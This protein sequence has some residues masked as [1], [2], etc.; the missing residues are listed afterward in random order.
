MDRIDKFLN[1]R[2]Q[3]NKRT[4]KIRDK[5]F[6]I[7]KEDIKVVRNYKKNVCLDETVDMYR[8][9]STNFTLDTM[10]KPLKEYRCIDKSESC[11]R[12]EKRNFI[13]KNK[14]RVTKEYKHKEINNIT[15]IWQ[16][17][18]LETLNNYE[19]NILLDIKEQYQGGVDDLK[20]EK[21]VLDKE[22]R[23]IYL[24]Q[25]LPRERKQYK[26]TDIIKES[27]KPESLKPYPTEVAKYWKIETNKDAVVSNDGTMLIIVNNNIL[28]VREINSV[29]IFK[30]IFNNKI[31]N[32]KF[33]YKKGIYFVSCGKL[34][35]LEE[36]DYLTNSLK[37]VDYSTFG[38]PEVVSTN[39]ISE[40]K[41]Y[42]EINL[43]EASFKYKVKDYD[44]KNDLVGCIVGRNL[45][46]INFRERRST[47]MY[48]IEGGTPHTIMFHPT[49][50]HALISTSNS[51]VVYDIHKKAELVNSKL[52]S[53][54]VSAKF[55][56]DVIYV[57]N[58]TGIVY[59]FDYIRNMIL[60]TMYQD[61]EILSVDV[62]Q[63]YN[64]LS[65]STKK[66][67]VVFYIDISK[68]QFVV[69]KRIGGLQ[70]SL[71]FDGVCPW[72]YSR[73]CGELVMYS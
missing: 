51:L 71:S 50:T 46:M 5:Y 67:L 11:L 13:K 48:K 59:I 1:R 41:I 53:Y 65:L 37:S 62:H 49:Y 14:D 24:K 52:F 25:Y 36:K 43:V 34:F 56:K 73:K 47:S 72:L 40:F 28:E 30:L 60:H 4:V 55:K 7:T 68:L 20:L 23:K 10:D 63:K 32:P 22:L 17:D 39:E 45:V 21:N 8:P 29:L 57:V 70:S 27:P 61:Q 58:N 35:V 66:E 16:D 31:E 2:K 12:R 64:L 9:Y 6:E 33:G 54:V 18:D 3:K 38:V 19:Q 15:D 44:W 26:V 42:K 69:V